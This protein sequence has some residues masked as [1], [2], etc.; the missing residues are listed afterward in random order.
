MIATLFLFQPLPKAAIHHSYWYTRKPPSEATKWTAESGNLVRVNY[1]LWCHNSPMF[2]WLWSHAFKNLFLPFCTQRWAVNAN[3]FS[4]LH[5]F[6]IKI[7]LS[8]FEGFC[9]C[10]CFSIKQ[11]T[12]WYMH[13]QHLEQNAC[14]ICF[15]LATY[16]FCVMSDLGLW[17]LAKTDQLIRPLQQPEHRLSLW[18]EMH[19]SYNKRIQ[20]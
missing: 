15:T 11:W 13:E 17:I 4:S 9:Y 1:F 8:Q 19:I 6:S 16:L 12:A 20:C 18:N 7:C 10:Q 3:W 14:T 2:F 5:F